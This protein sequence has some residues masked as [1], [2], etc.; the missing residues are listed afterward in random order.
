MNIKNICI[1]TGILVI[2]SAA[3]AGVAFLLLRKTDMI[4]DVFDYDDMEI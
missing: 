2:A 4:E 3:A 1:I